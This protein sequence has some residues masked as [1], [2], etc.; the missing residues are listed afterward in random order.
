MNN[1]FYAWCREYN[2]TQISKFNLN[3]WIVNEYSQFVWGVR[4]TLLT[5]STG[6][7]LHCQVENHMQTKFATPILYAID[8]FKMLIFFFYMYIT[9]DNIHFLILS[10]LYFVVIV[11]VHILVRTICFILKFGYH[12]N[13]VID[14]VYIYSWKIIHKS[15]THLGGATQ[16]N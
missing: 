15:L 4:G 5:Y 8:N 12:F 7:P 11:L 6:R 9:I 10:H 16:K 3:V 1:N 13:Y 14:N 2:S